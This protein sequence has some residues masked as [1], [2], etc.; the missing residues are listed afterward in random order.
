M[1]IAFGSEAVV[2]ERTEG[3][4]WQKAK[5][6]T[7]QC[8]DL[9]C[10]RIKAL[11]R[12][13]RGTLE[14]RSVPRAVT[15][16]QSDV[17]GEGRGALHPQRIHHGQEGQ[18][19][20][21]ADVPADNNHQG[22]R[23]MGPSTEGKRRRQ[24]SPRQ[25]LSSEAGRGAEEVTEAKDIRS[26]RLQTVS[27]RWRCIWLPITFK[28]KDQIYVGRQRQGTS[29]VEDMYGDDEEGVQNWVKLMLNS[30]Y[31]GVLPTPIEPLANEAQKECITGLRRAEGRLDYA[32][33]PVCL[34]EALHADKVIP[35]WP[36]PGEAAVQRAVGFIPAGM[37]ELLHQPKLL[38]L[39]QD[40]WPETP[41]KSKVRAT[42]E[43][44]TRI[45]RA[46]HE[47]KMMVGLRREEIFE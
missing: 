1:S 3:I 35:C 43:E 13:S 45:C 38:L 22:R 10:Q 2:G 27:Q 18:A 8:A 31:G 15:S 30:C 37:Q 36:K 4:F 42:H 17:A 20:R 19:V 40:Q 24:G 6:E 44:W 47:R 7:G 14:Q 16:P 39:P 5:G 12:A 41:P 9:L 29:L 34:M 21:E 46:G 32:G 26:H 25:A 33:E 28:M 11:D 23:K